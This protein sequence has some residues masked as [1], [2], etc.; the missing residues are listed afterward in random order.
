[1]KQF[2]SFRLDLANECLW[3]DGQPITLPP[4]PFALLRYLV[5]HPGR[6]ITHDELLDAIWP[7]TWVQPQ[8]LRTY[9]LELRK[10]LGDNIGRTR[11]IQ[12]QPKRGYRFIARVT[13][14]GVSSGEADESIGQA[15]AQRL[16]QT[17]AE[18]SAGISAEIMGE[19][20][21]AGIIGRERELALL[22]AQLPV[23]QKSRRRIV[24]ITGEAGIGKT[25]LVDAF[26]RRVAQSGDA[27]IARGQCIEG[28]RATE[29]YYP[30]MEALGRI[31]AGSE[32][33]RGVLARIAP[34]WLPRSGRS[35][36]TD[37]SEGAG[38]GDRRDR[39]AGDLCVAIEEL[40]TEQPLV[41]VLEDLHWADAATLS[42]LS[43]LARRRA[44]AKLL[45]VASC[46]PRE[47]EESQP[48]LR[49]RQDLL[50]RQLCAEIVLHPLRRFAV[51]QLLSRRLEQEPL[52]PGLAAFV[53][54]H[55]QGNP[56]F[57]IAILEHLIAQSYL[58]RVETQGAA[59][60]EQRGSFEDKEASIP[61]GL[62][63]MIDVDIE[64]LAPEEQRIL[65]AGSL[66]G[67]AFPVWAV[68]A[69]LD[70]DAAA[71]EEAC[72]ALARRVFFVQHGGH[73][74]LPGGA[75]SSFYVFVH[76]LYREVIYRRQ[77]ATRRFA[78][79]LRIARRLGE[80]F[81]GREASVA[82]EIA[83]QHEAA[84]DWYGAV[85]ALRLAAAH[86]AGRDAPGEAAELLERAAHL[87]GKLGERERSHVM[88][89]ISD[90]LRTARLKTG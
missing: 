61:S 78:G 22:H 43:A 56:L 4:K 24:F 57:A 7:E 35:S 36:L 37:D 81:A 33:A 46:A 9:V 44:A 8:V 55:S 58:V 80:I 62:A 30:V 69:A 82:R 40:T 5:D 49:L 26:C 90:E 21:A 1:M 60:W 23:V 31:C 10:I 54:Q 6:L 3:R 29:E 12:T 73:D 53:H 75:Q 67:I 66:S 38:H 88:G 74:E 87:A 76:S 34:G 39:L 84:T 18:I 48:C 2:E 70:A 52:P 17:Q 13:E 15:P 64:K 27:C 47:A 86:A 16:D 89:G 79:H 14:G 71:I 85:D 83:F 42:L 45:I 65:E 59:Q 32:R 68:A 63:Q 51:E 25:A 20:V 41:L 72:D 28:F 77:P 11:F 19:A 50:M